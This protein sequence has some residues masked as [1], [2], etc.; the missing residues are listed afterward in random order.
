[1]KVNDIVS[2]ACNDSSGDRWRLVMR[3]RGAS[4]TLTE[5]RHHLATVE[6]SPESIEKMIEGLQTI[7]AALSERWASVKPRAA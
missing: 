5:E 6:L 2:F 7:H 4:L 1:M 3:D